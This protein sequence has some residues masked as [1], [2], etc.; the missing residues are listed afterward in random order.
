M[1]TTEGEGCAHPSGRERHTWKTMADNL[2]HIADCI[3]SGAVTDRSLSSQAAPFISMHQGDEPQALPYIDP[4]RVREIADMRSRRNNMF[5]ADLFG[6]PVWD[7][8]LDLFLSRLENKRIC[9]TSLSIASN[10]PLTTALRY[11]ERMAD[12]GLIEKV[13]D[14][15]DGRRMMVSLTRDG[16]RKM[17]V[18]LAKS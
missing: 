17:H 18:L 5:G 13:D 7:M 9:I 2:R 6:E 4:Y 10:A 11:I 8:L 12:A 15:S 3:E 16:Y 1:D 14:P